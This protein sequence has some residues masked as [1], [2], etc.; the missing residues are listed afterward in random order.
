MWTNTTQS[1]INNVTANC[2]L[3]DWTNNVTYLRKYC[4]LYGVDH[5]TNNTYAIIII[6]WRQDLDF[7]MQL[8]QKILQKQKF[9]SNF[10]QSTINYSKNPEKKIKQQRDYGLTTY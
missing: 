4:N 1:W 6:V 7:E 3:E 10:V 2:N 5:V 8:I 9:K